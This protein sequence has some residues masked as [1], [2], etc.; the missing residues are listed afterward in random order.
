MSKIPLKG[1]GVIAIDVGYGFTKVVYEGVEI[2]FPTA[3]SFYTD[4]GISY[5]DSVVYEFEG[6]RY[7][8]GT[9]AEGTET[10]AT[11]SYSIIEKFGPLFIY[12]IL[13]KFE[14]AKLQM[15][16]EIRTGLALVDWNKKEEFAKRISEFSVN[17]EN[18][19][20]KPII[21]PQGVGV[22]N[23]YRFKE[24]SAE[25]EN[26]TILD[27]GYN[28]INLINIEKNKPRPDRSK[29]Y[30]GHGVSSIIK[31]FVGLLENRYKFSFSEQEAVQIMLKEKFTFNG[32]VQEDITE[33]IKSEKRKFI[34]KLFNSVLVNDKK[35]LGLSD[36]VIIAG[37]GAYMLKNVGLPNN[38]IF[39]KKNNEED[40]F[41]FA[42]SRG[43]YL[44]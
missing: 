12:H 16:I 44:I 13:N 14:N 21:V 39:L 15:P 22:F 30:P 19:K 1:K 41:E 17:G 27:I 11:T 36:K 31:P 7:V 9:N 29:S 38:C 37:G 34:Q 28:T 35:V 18:I 32:E 33:Y 40:A 4:N 2:K 25:K 20:T 10:F 23:A 42:N 5:G 6:E 24:P 3:I 43:Y 8:V 26:I